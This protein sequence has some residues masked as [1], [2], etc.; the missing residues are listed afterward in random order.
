MVVSAGAGSCPFP[1]WNHNQ[2]VTK[3]P[4]TAWNYKQTVKEGLHI[5]VIYFLDCLNTICSHCL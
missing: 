3:C 1:A 4:F 2:T 5:T